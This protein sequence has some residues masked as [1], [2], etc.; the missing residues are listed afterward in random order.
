MLVEVIFGNRV[1]DMCVLTVL[2]NSATLDIHS[3]VALLLVE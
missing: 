3:V 2:P 1:E